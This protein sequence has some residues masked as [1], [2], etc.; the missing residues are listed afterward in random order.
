MMLMCKMSHKEDSDSPAQPTA[1]PAVKSEQ[2]P[3]PKP[4]VK[5]EETALGIQGTSGE[6]EQLGTNRF[7]MDGCGM[8]CLSLLFHRHC[9]AWGQSGE[10]KR[11]TSTY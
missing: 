6:S 5:C 11:A 7:V 9:F 1:T 10:K 3:E 2:P 4:V 8:F